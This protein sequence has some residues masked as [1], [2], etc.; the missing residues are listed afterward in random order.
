MTDHPAAM[1]SRLRRLTTVGTETE[2]IDLALADLAPGEGLDLDAAG[3]TAVVVL[4]GRVEAS[5]AGEPLGIAGG[6][7]SVF[8]SP[9][10]T[11]YAPPGTPLALRAAD[12][13]AQLA[14][15]GAPTDADGGPPARIIGPDEQRVAEVGEGNW[16]RT[17]RTILGPEHDAVRLLLGETLNP[18]GNWS[19]YPPHRHDRHD[20]PREVKLEEVYL[21]KLDPPGGF[22]LQIL[23]EEGGPEASFLVRDDD[24]AVIRRGFHP[25]VAASGYT[26]YYLWAMAGEGREMMPYLDP[27]HAWVQQGR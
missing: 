4:S 5:A 27:A 1:E 3:E 2:H 22:G 6:R 26:L 23:Y 21:F 19:S 11:V 16:S 24:V 20:P 12:G 10:D 18:P 8:E 25:V 9:G 13:Q 14:V 17:V 15:V 7:A